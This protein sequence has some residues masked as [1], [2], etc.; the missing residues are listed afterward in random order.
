MNYVDKIQR[1]SD[2]NRVSKEKKDTEV[3]EHTENSIQLCGA[4][5]DKS[6]KI[7]V[8]S[9]QF[10]QPRKGLSTEMGVPDHHLTCLLKTL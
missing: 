6:S 1:K 10:H 5:S 7:L 8:L 3:T 4:N 2:S 9:P